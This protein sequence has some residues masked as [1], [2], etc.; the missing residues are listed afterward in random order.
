MYTYKYDPLL[1][2][3]RSSSGAIRAI[4]G[5]ESGLGGLDRSDGGALNEARRPMLLG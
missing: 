4:V 2:A 1:L 5:V 3:L